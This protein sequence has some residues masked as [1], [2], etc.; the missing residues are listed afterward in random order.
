M[1]KLE[2]RF[3]GS[4][5]IGVRDSKGLHCKVRVGRAGQFQTFAKEPPLGRGVLVGCDGSLGRTP[6]I[7]QLSG[8]RTFQKEGRAGAKVLPS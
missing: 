8:G 4:G 3:L 1:Q 2:T 6:K 5:N 7:H